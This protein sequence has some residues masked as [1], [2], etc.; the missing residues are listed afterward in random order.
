MASLPLPNKS[1]IRT[2]EAA[3]EHAARMETQSVFII[4]CHINQGRIQIA[5]NITR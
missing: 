3:I 5:S 2:L 4:A 1:I